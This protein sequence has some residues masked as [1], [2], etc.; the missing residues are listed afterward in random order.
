MQFL[1]DVINML[2][3]YS[4]QSNYKSAEKGDLQLLNLDGR[5]SCS[6]DRHVQVPTEIY[7]AG[8]KGKKSLQSG[9]ESSK[10]VYC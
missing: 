5:F 9:A 6:L 2:M 10:A 4:F 8:A 7:F 3:N 1:I